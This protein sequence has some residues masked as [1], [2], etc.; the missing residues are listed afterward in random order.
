MNSVLRTPHTPLLL[1]LCSLLAVYNLYQ[2]ITTALSDMSLQ[3]NLF[4]DLYNYPVTICV[5]IN[6]QWH[7]RESDEE[8]D[9]CGVDVVFSL[10]SLSLS[11]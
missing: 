3:W 11:F 7:S 1:L 4:R 2:M 8:E 5:A 9:N 10:E 6:D